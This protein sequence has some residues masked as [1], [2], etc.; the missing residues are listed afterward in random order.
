MTYSSAYCTIPALTHPTDS[1]IRIQN[2]LK[3]QEAIWARTM[4]MSLGE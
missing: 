2:W 1:R 4:L 3:G